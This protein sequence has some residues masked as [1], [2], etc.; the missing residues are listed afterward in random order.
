M[1]SRVKFSG[2]VFIYFF[3]FLMTILSWVHLL[4]VGSR[5]RDIPAPRGPDRA[6]LR[7]HETASIFQ[8]S[9]VRGFRRSGGARAR[10]G[11]R[12]RG[13]GPSSTMD[14]R[15]VVAPFPAPLFLLS[16]SAC[17]FGIRAMSCVPVLPRIWSCLETLP[18]IWCWLLDYGFRVLARIRIHLGVFFLGMCES[19]LSYARGLLWHGIWASQSR[20]SFWDKLMQLY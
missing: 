15:Q 11:G 4:A 10:G 6:R 7:G 3:P 2:D 12:G 18:R 16:P 17:E 8:S 13:G 19:Q 20:F 1:I 9:R 14:Q 5:E